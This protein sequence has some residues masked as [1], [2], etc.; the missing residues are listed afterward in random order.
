MNNAELDNSS[1]CLQ[2]LSH[3]SPAS[4]VQTPTAW[5]I[6]LQVAPAGRAARAWG[7]APKGL[8]PRIGC[9]LFLYASYPC[10]ASTWFT[11]WHFAPV[12]WSN[13]HAV[14]YP[15]HRTVEISLIRYEHLPES[16]CSSPDP[17][18]PN[19][20]PQIAASWPGETRSCSMR[21]PQPPTNGHLTPTDAS[22]SRD[23]QNHKIIGA[24]PRKAARWVRSCFLC[25]LWPCLWTRSS[26]KPR[27]PVCSVLS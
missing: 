11:V 9:P 18:L 7:S 3:N 14:L 16:D 12:A 10:P 4:P 23:C 6:N 19:W 1:I 2:T 8:H 17:W 24:I 21:C 15:P 20:H 26:R 22:A 27:Q 5:F 13:L 25:W